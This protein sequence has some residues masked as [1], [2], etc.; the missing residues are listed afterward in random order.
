M[1]DVRQAGYWFE[2]K[3]IKQGRNIIAVQFLL[4]IETKLAEEK[5][6]RKDKQTETGKL[7][8]ACTRCIF[9]KHQMGE[10]KPNMRTKLCKFCVANNM[11][12][13]AEMEDA[14]QSDEVADEK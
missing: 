11:R 8:A 5:Q 14:P 4:S 10:C 6:Q 3:F 2:P 13:S 9:E 1:E 7:F 12:G